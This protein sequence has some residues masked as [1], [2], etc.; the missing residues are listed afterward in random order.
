MRGGGRMINAIP[1]FGVV[2]RIWPGAAPRRVG[3]N[4][5]QVFRSPVPSSIAEHSRLPTA[6]SATQDR[7]VEAARWS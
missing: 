1:V 3:Q 5:T 6:A 2:Q 4:T 7:S